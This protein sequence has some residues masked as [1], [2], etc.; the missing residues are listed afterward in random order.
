MLKKLSIQNYALI[1]N[2]EIDFDETLNIITGETGAGKSIVLGALS[3]ILGQRA[4][5]K[6]FFNQEKKCVIEGC[7]SNT[8]NSL[9]TLFD[10]FELDFYSENLLRREI[11]IDGRS[12]A[13][14]NDTP[15]NVGTLKTIGEQLIAIHSQ[16]ATL[17]IGNAD[18]Q[19]LILDSLASQQDFFLQY[20][21][22]YK[23]LKKLER[24]LTEKQLAIDEAKK[25]KD[26]EQFLFDELDVAK[27]AADEQADLESKLE[28]LNH[29]E[30]IKNSLLG[31]LQWLDKADDSILLQLR[32]ATNEL[33]SAERYD[34]TLSP[35][36]ERLKSCLIE[37]K[38]VSEELE[39]IAD[40]TQHDNQ[41]LET[42]QQRLD[43]IYGLQNKHRVQSIAEL[44][45]LKTQLSD[46][47]NAISQGDEQVERLTQAIQQLKQDLCKR[48]E[49]L[50]QE[51]ASA[52]KIAENEIGKS[53]A[54]MGMPNA[55]VHFELLKEEEITTNG[56]DRI[57]LA[58]TANAGQ[59]AMPVQKVASGGELSRL[60]LAT[61]ALLAK[62]TELPTLIFDEIDTGISGE[63][64][65]KVA[66]VIQNL[67]ANMQLIAITHLPQ[68]AAK[69]NSH[70][71]VYKN[72]ENQKTQ[73]QLKKLE[74]NERVE[75][76]AEMLSGKNP[77]HSALQ[78][79]K[80]LLAFER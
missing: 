53:L 54:E 61:K 18:F 71:L 41:L 73:T 74:Q 43:V 2:L 36:T 79:A 47:L 29:A 22:D 42:I 64:A 50:H 7:F 34:K 59:A 67:A 19:F 17:E 70:Y 49:K 46:N 39:Q 52:A 37:L 45:D 6:Y 69:G 72:D 30:S 63:V 20:Q 35:L 24:E 57:S 11:S 60:M 75:V 16:H 58:F 1:D 26:Y 14:I 4:E 44:I 15:V 28:K 10:S 25:R 40:E 48:A 77:A 66:T 31:S 32:Q 8:H 13:F 27:L 38:D 21:Q 78:N 62:H 3:L 80:D 76:L 12:R 65:R 68:I 56:F 51:R 9:K 55:K 23:S 33:S 5:S